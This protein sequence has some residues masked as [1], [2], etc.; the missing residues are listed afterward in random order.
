ME[1]SEGGEGVRAEATMVGA[2]ALSSSLAHL[3]SH[4]AKTHVI[5]TAYRCGGGDGGDDVGDN[6][7]GDDGAVSYNG[8]WVS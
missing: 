4:S 1:D 3:T 7:G 8:N 2:V 6:G 5:L